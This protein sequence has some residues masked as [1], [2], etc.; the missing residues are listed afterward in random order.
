MHPRVTDEAISESVSSSKFEQRLSKLKNKVEAMPKRAW[1]EKDQK[2]TDEMVQMIDNLLLKRGFNRSLECYVGERTIETDYRLRGSLLQHP[3]TKTKVQY[4]NIRVILYSIYSDDGNPTSAN[5]KQALWQGGAWIAE[6][7]GVQGEGG[8]D[9]YSSAAVSEIGTYTRNGGTRAE[10]TMKPYRT[11][12]TDYTVRRRIIVTGS[13]GGV[14][15]QSGESRHVSL[16]ACVV[17]E[18]IVN[19][20]LTK[21]SRMHHIISFKNMG[22]PHEGQI[23]P[24]LN[25]PTHHQPLDNLFLL[26]EETIGSSSIKCSIPWACIIASDP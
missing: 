25:H 19:G 3:I 22:F 4:R 18:G 2:R 15:H 14:G 26:Q 10:R 17:H 11:S 13:H 8:N 12:D 6:R 5:I 21:S 9:A 24:R 23:Y 20:T 16:G 1:T 7:V